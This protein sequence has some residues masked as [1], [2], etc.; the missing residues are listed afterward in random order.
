M[1]ISDLILKKVYESLIKL[2]LNFNGKILKI[3]Q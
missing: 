3:V 2:Q 1:P